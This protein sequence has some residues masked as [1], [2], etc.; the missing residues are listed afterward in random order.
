MT[1]IRVGTAY[2][3]PP[4]EVWRIL[5]PIE[6]HVDWMADAEIIRFTTDQTRGVGT[7]FECV[8]RVGPVRLTDKM[9]ITEWEPGRSMGVTHEGLVTA[10]GFERGTGVMINVMPPETAAETLRAVRTPA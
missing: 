5:E 6:S 10:A 3:A 9:S 8:T 7:R 4:A 2:D 1:L